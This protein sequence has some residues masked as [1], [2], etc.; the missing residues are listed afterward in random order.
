MPARNYHTILGC[1]IEDPS[2]LVIMYFRDAEGEKVEGSVCHGFH[3]DLGR[4]WMG[5]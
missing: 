1:E 5:Q 2:V 3:D 4:A